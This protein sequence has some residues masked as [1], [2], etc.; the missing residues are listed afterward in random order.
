MASNKK[1][2]AQELVTI[3]ARVKAEMLRRSRDAA[4]YNY[5]GTAYDYT[6]APAANTK[7]AL[8]HYDKVI[9][10]LRAVNPGS[11]P[12][13]GAKPVSEADMTNIGA[14]ITA[15][16]TK[17]LYGGSTDCASG[18]AGMCVSCSGSCTGGCSGCYGC[19]GACSYGCTGCSGTCSG[20]CNDTCTGSCTGGCTDACTGCTGTCTGSCTS[21]TGTCNTTCTGAC[22]TNCKGCGSGCDD[23]CYKT[24]V[25]KCQSVCVT[26]SHR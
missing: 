11:L 6:N 12:A 13:L 10:P 15:F 21:C 23:G 20:T 22:V 3:K 7:V 14:S 16:E 19:G 26:G 4:I 9:E 18:C 1:I 17:T 2:D 8:E 5:G 25:A 24:C